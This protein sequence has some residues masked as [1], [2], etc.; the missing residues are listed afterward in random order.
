MPELFQ[1]YHSRIL[2]TPFASLSIGGARV[3]YLA[4]AEPEHAALPPVLILPGV[5]QDFRSLLFHARRLLKRR[6][7]I[8]IA[9]PG[10]GGN[11]QLAPD[12][13][14]TELADLLAAFLDQVG[15]K[16]VLPQAFSYGAVIV[17]V[18]CTSYPRL[19]E[20]AILG[21]IFHEI[22][23]PFHD[24]LIE[25]RHLLKKNSMTD[26][27]T[28]LT[29]NM[30]N[31]QALPQTGITE[32]FKRTFHQYLQH[33]PEIEKKRYMQNISRLIEI[34]TLPGKPASPALFYAGR[35]DNFAPPASV[36][37]SAQMFQNSHFAL[38]EGADH[39]MM[40]TKKETLGRL[41]DLYIS[42]Q[43]MIEIEGVTIEAMQK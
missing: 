8:L 26:F 33:L 32:K 4:L 23:Q 40:A 27:A 1:S 14:L 5:F 35:Q 18:F 25:A 34:D 20:K 43:E 3:E 39:M 6:P 10:Q 2:E 42:Q 37:Q 7:V 11:Q 16:T 41:F 17:Y 22:D 12:M 15:V 19:I 36:R 21:G 31:Q 28:H 29:Q 9:L 13:N 38:L 30:I 24:F